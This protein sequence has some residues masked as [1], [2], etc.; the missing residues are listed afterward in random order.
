MQTDKAQAPT[1]SYDGKI[2]NVT[3]DKLTCTCAKGH[4]HHYRVAKEAKISCDGKDALL[5]DL[6][7]SSTIRMTMC[8][9]DRS[10]VLAI[11]C[12]KHIPTLTKA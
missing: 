11:D 4:E 3:G 2:V 1:N 9:D 10:K 8:K 6:K 12:G 7:T 5:T